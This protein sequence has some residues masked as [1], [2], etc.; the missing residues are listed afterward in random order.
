VSVSEV[1]DAAPARIRI[2]L[3]DDHELIRRG[4]R[5]FLEGEPDME[6]VDEAASARDAVGKV[7][8]VKPDLVVLDIRLPDG[9]GVEV[10]RELRARCPEAK[11]IMLTSFADDTALMDS[12]MAGASGYILK[13]TKQG[14]LLE[15][16]RKVAA[17]QSLI[18]PAITASVF[19]RLRRQAESSDALEALTAQER[20]ILDL[21]AEGLTNREIAGRIHLAERTVK[22]YVS[23]I[24]AKLGMKHRT[25][26][27]L[28][29]S[30]LR[31][32]E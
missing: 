3:V 24:L 20:R 12:I 6:V 22:N 11:V 19:R 21:I 9:N 26:V 30:K 7:P 29:A 15:A 5:A 32:S 13:A 4:L 27:A 10:C 23:H 14:E 2:F 17:G 18:D 28:Y 1:P 16:L 25:Q 31:E 8:I